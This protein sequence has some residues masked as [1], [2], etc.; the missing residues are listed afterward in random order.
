MGVLSLA[1]VP[2][3]TWARWVLPLQASLFVLGLIALAVA[4]SIGYA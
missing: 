1:R 4:V 3:P 2:W